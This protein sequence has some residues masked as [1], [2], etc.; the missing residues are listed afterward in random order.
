MSEDKDYKDKK[1]KKS[2][3]DDD[4]DAVVG[5]LAGTSAKI[6]DSTRNVDN[7]SN[8]ILGLSMAIFALSVN[9]LMTVEKL[10][11]TLSVIAIFSGISSM[12]ALLAIRP[13][14]FLIKKGQE[15]SLMY[16]R[17][18]AGFASHKEYA[19]ALREV[20]T[21]DEKLFHQ[22]ATEIYNLS[23]FYYIPKRKMF[24]LSRNIFLFGVVAALFFML[25]EIKFK[26]NFF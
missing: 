20:L 5:F 19:E 23:R 13:P 22:Y 21:S 1:D 16:T 10:H 24:S 15:E 6:I 26:M 12:V 11:M 25:L 18:I 9:E 4:L 3:V 14:R 17:K 7:H 8:V 2:F